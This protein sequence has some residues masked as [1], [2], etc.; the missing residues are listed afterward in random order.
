MY[1]GCLLL[2]SV[3]VARAQLRFQEDPIQIAIRAY[4]TAREQG[5]FDEAVAKR[6]LARNLLD[7]I[8]GDSPQLGNSA[9]NIAQLYDSSGFRTQALA[10]AQQALARATAPSTRMELLEMAADFYQQDGN[11]LHAVGYREK[12][13]AALEEAAAKP[14]APNTSRSAGGGVI[15]NFATGSGLIS[16]SRLYR[17]PVTPERVYQ[18]LADLYQQLGRPDAVAAI[19]KRMLL[20]VK[21]PGSLAQIYERQGQ[22]EEAGAI[23]KKQAEQ[24]DAPVRA[25][26]LQALANLYQQEQR[27]G[28]AADALQQA[29]AV[30]KSSGK[31]EA[32]LQTIYIRI[33][34]A[35]MLNRAGQ[36]EAADQ[37]YEQL[38]AES[39]GSEDGTRAHILN[40]YA[41]YL[42]DTKRDA[43]GQALLS[44][45]L[46]SHPN[47]EPQ[48]EASL[49]MQL[50]YG[51]RRS[52]NSNL[53]DQY[54][55]T[56][57]EKQQAW[58]TPVTRQTLIGPDLQA[59]QTAAHAGK[60]DEAYELS[61]QAM[62]SAP[63][64]ADRDQV[65]WGVPNV[66]TELAN[67]K[68]SEKA[69][70]LYQRLFGLVES[71]SA[72]SP[73]ALMNVL[74]NYSRFAKSPDQ[75]SKALAAIQ[76]YRDSAIITHGAISGPVVDALRLTM[77]FERMHGSPQKVIT[78][79]E[80]LVSLQESLS[81]NTSEPYLRAAEDLAREYQ[82]NGDP[83]RAI[84][85]FRRNVAIADLVYRTADA[86]R[87][88]TRITAATALA[89]QRQFDEAERLAAEAIAIANAMRPP[90]GNIFG[91]QLE[92]IR[93]MKAAPA[94]NPPNGN[95]PWF[96]QFKP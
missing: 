6:D 23:Y 62:T 94:S 54:Q 41:N 76:R 64:A 16:I 57:N 52:G 31:A 45:Y 80:D 43:R 8:P 91:N 13:V 24:G 50:S 96:H 19:N 89:Q 32:E 75:A 77:Q 33:N 26:A 35:G 18:Q 3:G 1:R 71:W 51:A 29:N 90:Q 44:D 95:N 47:L 86:R 58:Q 22:L 55:R 40:S 88:H 72:E 7:Q 12:A 74:Q 60:F 70:R 46:T 93:K 85:I 15:G 48:V 27:F 39:S 30:W 63:T 82:S 73:Q 56:S 37:V 36:T 2:L 83:E 4:Q 38:L 25:G 28:E 68:E 69:E 17:A 66:A 81:G 67:R 53:A 5:Q 10:I 79:A 20:A 21:D 59:A 78:A 49:L 84:P 34:L 65:A 61:L 87:A 42:N 11:L 14:A 92:Q 9:R